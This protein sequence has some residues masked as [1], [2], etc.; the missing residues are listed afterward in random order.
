MVNI[1]KVG[2][3][4][5]ISAF[6]T[7]QSPN[8]SCVASLKT[9]TK[10]HNVAPVWIE[11]ILLKLKTENRKY[12]SK[13]ILKCV[14]SAVWLIFNEKVDKKWNLWVREQCTDALFTKDWSKVAVLFTYSIWTVAVL[15]DFFTVNNTPVHCLW[16]YKF[17]FS[18]IFSLKMSHTAL[19]TYLKIILLQYFQF[20]VF[21]FSKISSIQTDPISEFSNQ[22]PK[23][24]FYSKEG[25][26]KTIWVWAHL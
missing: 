21:S 3:R 22:Y 2:C 15:V 6:R 4:L 13:I 18:A 17:H 1:I 12:C 7:E 25:K 23:N 19:F 20:L 24:N 11:F 8:P 9:A 14:N 26:V 10:S 16:T 5:I